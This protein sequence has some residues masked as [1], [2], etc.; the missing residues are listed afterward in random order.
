VGAVVPIGEARSRRAAGAP[1]AADPADVARRLAAGQRLYTA[2]ELGR[3]LR[4]SPRSIR[5]DVQSGMPRVA[6]GAAGFRFILA[7]VLAWHDARRE[8]AGDHHEG[9]AA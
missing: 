3:H 9:S 7:D 6:V 8:A 1:P 2:E 5:R 4:R